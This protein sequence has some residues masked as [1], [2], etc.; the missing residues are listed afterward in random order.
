VGI[1]ARGPIGARAGWV[2]D[3]I[4]PLLYVSI[5]NE[6]SSAMLHMVQ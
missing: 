3:L 6:R 4:P 1:A 2:F 5:P